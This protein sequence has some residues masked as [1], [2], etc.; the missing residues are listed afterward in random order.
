MRPDEIRNL[1]AAYSQ[2]KATTPFKVLPLPNKAQ[3]R[4]WRLS[5]RALVAGSY[6]D[7]DAAFAWIL[8]VELPYATFKSFGGRPDDRFRKLDS[9]LAAGLLSVASGDLGREITYQSE[10]EAKVGRLIKGRQILWIV[11]EYYHSRGT[12]GS[13]YD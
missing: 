4:A 13:L 10:L 7:S 3:F 5:L 1:S 12:A 6:I 11:Y 2:D 9:L 8:E